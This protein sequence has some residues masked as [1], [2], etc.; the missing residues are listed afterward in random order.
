MNIAETFKKYWK[1]PVFKAFVIVFVA[2][3]VTLVIR[4]INSDTQETE[5]NTLPS[6]SLASASSLSQTESVSLIGTVRAFTEAQITTERAGRVT[7]V[8]TSLGSQVGAGQI[9]ATLENASEQAA[10]LQAQGVYE[11]ALAN[12]AQ[13]TISVEEAQTGLQSARNSL[14]TSIKS[15]YNTA[16]SAIRNDIDDFYGNPDAFVPGLKLDGKGQTQSLNAERVAF[17]TL[18]SEWQQRSNS[19]TTSSNLEVES[20]YAV[21]N[22]NRTISLLDTFIT[23]FPLQDANGQYS[24]AELQSFSSSFTGLR[25]SLLQAVASIESAQSGIE[26]A[27][28][29]ALRAEQSATG[30][31]ASAAD[32][33]V[34]QA[35]GSLRAAQAN[36][37]KTILRTPI[38]GTVNSLDIKVGD[39][40]GSFETVSIVF[41]TCS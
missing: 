37:A 28:D 27:E 38:S 39:F 30:G 3:I 29:A 20:A 12:A 31:T 22:L 5:S 23:L 15:A 13:S 11:A 32:A 2:L 21:Q 40:V 16:N 6:V 8:S 33:Q 9:I 19:I 10:V 18:L 1:K 14:V 7:S 41:F 17:Q 4:G 24:E 25:G 26:R 36:L 34:K 35:L